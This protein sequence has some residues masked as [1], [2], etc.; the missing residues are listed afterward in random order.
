MLRDEYLDDAATIVEGS[1][2]V[3]ATIGIE[4]GRVAGAAPLN[5]PVL[6]AKS[7]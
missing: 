3:C 1:G 6:H 5:L 2:G 7:L 4:R